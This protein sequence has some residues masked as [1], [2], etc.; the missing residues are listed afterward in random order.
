M[1]INDVIH[2]DEEYKTL[3]EP[4]LQRSGGKFVN[5]GTEE[6]ENVLAFFTGRHFS[7]SKFFPGSMFFGH[8]EFRVLERKFGVRNKAAQVQLKFHQS[9]QLPHLFEDDKLQ[10]SSS[11]MFL[12]R[13]MEYF[14]DVIPHMVK[15]TKAFQEMALIQ[16]KCKLDHEVG[17]N[18]IFKLYTQK[19]CKYECNIKKAE[20]MCNCIPWDF[21]HQKYSLAKECDLFG[22]TCFYN[23][24]EFV[25]KSRNY[26]R[27]FCK[28]CVKEC[29]YTKFD[30]I[31]TK[32]QKSPMADQSF[33]GSIFFKI[34]ENRECHG[35]KVFCDFFWPDNGVN[36]TDKGLN[37][38]FEVL[39]DTNKKGYEY[40]Q[41][42]MARDLVIVHFRIMEPQIDVMDAKYS[43]FDKIANFGGKFGIFTQ[44]TGCSFLVMLNF[45]ILLF[46][47]I[48]SPPQI[49]N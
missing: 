16:R 33:F 34:D 39:K 28:H 48:F 49:K 46:K 11:S 9:K 40:E 29:D 20:E 47:L 10:H 1:E 17:M 6:S 8:N 35:E 4:N 18:S 24:M 25:S 38:S 13:G 3:F 30:G 12:D 2:I 41:F 45:L 26:S 43:T 7:H 19:N 14:I 42:E 36:Y 27:N 23:A 37:N 31:I 44:V 15:T 32:Q 5:V 22:R 21:L